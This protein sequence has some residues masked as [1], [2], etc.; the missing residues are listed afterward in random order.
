MPTYEPSAIGVGGWVNENKAVDMDILTHT[1]SGVAVG[2]VAASFSKAGFTNKLKIVIFSGFAGALPDFD[3]ISLWSGFDS[4][5][6]AFFNLPDSG[7]DIY[8]AKL[9]YSHHAFMHSVFA[10]ILF[11]GLIGLLGYLIDS[12]FMKLRPKGFVHS[13]K[14]QKLVLI[15]FLFAFV[16]H[17]LEDMPTPSSTWGGVNFFWPSGNYI[18][19]SGDIWWWNNYDIFLIVVTVLFVNLTLPLFKKL[20]PIKI[21]KLTVIV[22]LFGFT[23]AFIQIKTR[24]YNFAYSGYTKNYQKMEAKSK[25]LQ[26][27]ILGDKVYRLMEKFDNQLKFYF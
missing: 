14:R 6:G 24:N 27:K 22:F 15:A 2:T 26:K 7:R 11:A 19:G 1:L 25:E 17:L 18:G 20:I 13:I 5:I 12:K 3:A 16:L 8:S 23:L 21:S 9:W 10:G 4:T